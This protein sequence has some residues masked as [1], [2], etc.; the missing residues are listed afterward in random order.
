MGC[1]RSIGWRVTSFGLAFCISILPEKLRCRNKVTV[2]WSSLL[3]DW[4]GSE[5]NNNHSDNLR[6]SMW[7]YTLENT[8]CLVTP[9]SCPLVT[10]AG[11]WVTCHR[12]ALSSSRHAVISSSRLASHHPL[13]AP[14]SHRLIAQV[15][16]CCVA[17]RC[18][19]V[20]QIRYIRRWLGC[21]SDRKK[22]TK[23]FFRV[24][25]NREF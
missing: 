8:R 25:I 13:V 22:A 2:D 6:S 7:N 4:M 17:S 18:A 20:T 12:A 19:A 23:A 5:S 21:S 15:G 11:C 14:P 9:S 3:H 1:L 24:I 10:P 16:C